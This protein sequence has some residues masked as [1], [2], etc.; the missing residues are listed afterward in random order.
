M[1]YLKYI[2]VFVFVFVMP[3]IVKAEETVREN[4]L[5]CTYVGLDDESSLELQIIMPKEL[6]DAPKIKLN[7]FWDFLNKDK[8][9]RE[10]DSNYMKLEKY[11]TNCPKYVLVNTDNVL[12]SFWSSLDKEEL[13]KTYT[14]GFVWEVRDNVSEFDEIKWFNT[15]TFANPNNSLN[16]LGEYGDKSIAIR[17]ILKSQ[18]IY[19]PEEKTTKCEYTNIS[20]CDN[21]SVSIEFFKNAEEVGIGKSVVKDVFVNRTLGTGWNVYSDV[22]FNSLQHPFSVVSSFCPRMDE[23]LIFEYVANTKEL[24]ISVRNKDNDDED[25]FN[26]DTD[27]NYNDVT[28]SEKIEC[29]KLGILNE[30]IKS[31]FK[32]VKIIVPILVVVFSI[33]DF[34][35]AFTGKVEGEMKK[36]FM[37]LVK[38]FIFA[39]ILFFLPDLL[40]LVL[41]WVDPR[42]TTCINSK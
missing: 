20:G 24:N 14:E 32:I 29:D 10:L 3:I 37:K 27:G 38:R 9:Q 26:I 13:Y 12:E 36:A 31:L 40:E 1:K 42:Y 4:A 5:E 17:G 19:N 8:A 34:V 7:K 28:A 21:C 41:K 6:K 33:Y 22:H 39:V 16:P 11:K 15:L 30:D 25:L 18:K 2:V 23:D 35:K